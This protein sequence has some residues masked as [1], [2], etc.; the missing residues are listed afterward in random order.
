MQGPVRSTIAIGVA[1]LS[2][3]SS[4]PGSAAVS[5]LWITE[6][7]PDTGQVEVTN[8]GAVP[9]TITPNFRWCHRFSYAAVVA[10]DT[11][12]APGESRV[13]T[14]AGLDANL[15]EIWLYQAPAYGGAVG[16]ASI[17]G[18]VKYGGSTIVGREGVATNAGVWD[19]TASF[20]PLPPTVPPFAQS[21]QVKGPNPFAAAHWALATPNLGSYS[22]PKPPFAITGISLVESGMANIVWRGGEA[23]YQVQSSITGTTGSWQNLGARTDAKSITLAVSGTTRFFRVLT[24]LPD[25][26]AIYDV[27][28]TSTWTPETHPDFPSGAHFTGLI[29]G[30]HGSDVAFWEP[31]SLA[32]PG[33]RNMAET[34]SKSPLNAE[35]NAAITAGTAENLLSGGGLSATPGSVTL[36]FSASLDFP[37]VSLVSMI[38]PSPDWFVGVHGLSL[39]VDGQ[40]AADLT[41]ELPPYDA[42]TDSGGT[43]TSGNVETFPPAPISRITGPPLGAEGE[44][45]PF[46]TFRFVR[47][48]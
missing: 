47:V 26:T 30:T 28:F 9:V 33:I 41:V 23:P 17:V 43:F 25:L 3:A 21:L 31:D 45:A 35:V 11:S 27:T 6:V 1:I 5:D 22:P 15:S 18:G 20:V 13:F 40:W 34:G 32:S 29:G 10:S 12:F 39:L 14:V 37:L 36:R 48:P 19:G 24:G 16:E 2:F 38:A 44:V 8:T 46:G 42:G 7:V 4:I